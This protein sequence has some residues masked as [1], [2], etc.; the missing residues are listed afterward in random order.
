MKMN[1]IETIKT[2][3]EKTIISLNL[4]PFAK[5]PYEAGKMFFS[6]S[7]F[8]FTDS[9]SNTI[10]F[11]D[12][13]EK[14]NMHPE[15]SNGL[16]IFPNAP[17]DFLEFYDFFCLC[18]DLLAELNMEKEFQIVCFHPAF[19]FGG[20]QGDERINAVNQSPLAC[21]HLLRSKEVFDA[22]DSPDK[23]LKINLANE[24]AIESLSDK[25][26]LNHFKRS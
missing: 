26:F 18:E 16:I 20:M 6:E 24:K 3:L 17:K 13:L 19:R 9:K 12:E 5:A 2:W 7:N 25:E 15:L 8:P 14:L 11:L 4:C 23:G 21:I 1:S 10:L 22:L